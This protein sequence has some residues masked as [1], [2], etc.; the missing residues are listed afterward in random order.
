MILDPPSNLVLWVP[1]STKAR[2]QTP[3]GAS[4]QYPRYVASLLVAPS[5]HSSTRPRTSSPCTQ[6]IGHSVACTDNEKC[7]LSSSCQMNERMRSAAKYLVRGGRSTLICQFTLLSIHN[8]RNNSLHGSPLAPHSCSC[9][10]ACR[11]PFHVKHFITMLT[12]SVQC[13]A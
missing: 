8:P 5:A 7:K 6:V 12:A 10:R 13:F 3:L 1:P 2:L 9:W 11:L 4:V